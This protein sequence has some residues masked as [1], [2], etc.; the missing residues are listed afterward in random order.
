V[1]VGHQAAT[2]LVAELNDCTAH[3]K[4]KNKAAIELF[5]LTLTAEEQ[6]AIEEAD[7]SFFDT[8]LAP[9][10][11]D[12]VLEQLRDLAMA[13][14]PAGQCTGRQ[15]ALGRLEAAGVWQLPDHSSLVE[16]PACAGERLVDRGHYV[17]GGQAHGD[18]VAPS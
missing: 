10:D 12:V 15:G 6:K 8:S 14:T 1:G 13:R 9:S 17:R 4:V 18:R 7:L 2:A 11:V 5:N 3:P 16:R